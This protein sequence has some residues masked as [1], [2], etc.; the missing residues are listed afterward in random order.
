MA[1]SCHGELLGELECSLPGPRSR[2]EP[3][4]D[5]NKTCSLLYKAEFC[6]ILLGFRYVR[7]RF[8]YIRLR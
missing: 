3:R 8:T 2:A 7:L 1:I 6:Y 4:R 5:V